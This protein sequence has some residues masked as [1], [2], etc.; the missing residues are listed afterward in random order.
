MNPRH[1]FGVS[2]RWGVLS[3]VGVTAAALCLTGGSSTLI[4]SGAARTTAQPAHA[5]LDFLGGKWGDATAD[6]VS[7][8][9]YGKNAAE[10][11]PGSLFTITKATQARAL[12]GKKDKL[13]RSVTGQGVG[14]A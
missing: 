1:S 12:W 14:V 2:T 7:K 3:A 8:D 4:A 11:D 13:G 5:T 9:S 10:K 6:S